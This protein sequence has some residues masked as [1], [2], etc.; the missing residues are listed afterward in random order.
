MDLDSFVAYPKKKMDEIV[1]TLWS[2]TATSDTDHDGHVPTYVGAC[3]CNTRSPPYHYHT[4][5]LVSYPRIG[6][7]NKF[8]LGKR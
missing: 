4:P 1:Y 5:Y 7:Y 2:M 8:F 3:W 6:A